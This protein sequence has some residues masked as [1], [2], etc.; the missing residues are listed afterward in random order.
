MTIISDHIQYNIFKVTTNIYHEKKKKAPNL[1]LFVLFFQILK[2]F[3]H[4]IIILL[5]KIKM[6]NK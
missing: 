2:F 3:V 6:F 1:Y 5:S 4:I